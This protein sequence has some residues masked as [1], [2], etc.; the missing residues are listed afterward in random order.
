[1][2]S[3]SVRWAPTKSHVGR[4]GRREGWHSRRR[5]AGATCRWP[6]VRRRR[7]GE[8]R[9]AQA[10]SSAAETPDLARR[11]QAVHSLVCVSVWRSQQCTGGD[12]DGVTDCH[13]QA[14]HGHPSPLEPPSTTSRR[15]LTRRRGEAKTI[16]DVVGPWLM[17]GTFGSLVRRA[18]GGL[19]LRAMI[20]DI[21]PPWTRPWLHLQRLL[22]PYRPNSRTVVDSPRTM[23]T[24]TPIPSHR[25]QAFDSLF[26]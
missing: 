15:T 23:M 20:W 26:P 11:R 17:S 14:P 9:A 21:G 1:M 25:L 2:D 8:I 18:R 4:E 12:L 13:K 19:H 22:R 6:H 16:A 24:P 7:F 5:H 3:V 10:N